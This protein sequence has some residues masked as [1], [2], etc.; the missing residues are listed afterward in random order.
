M[1]APTSFCDGFASADPSPENAFSLTGSKLGFTRRCT[2]LCSVVRGPD[3][4][5]D[6]LQQADEGRA[7]RCVLGV[8]CIS[9]GHV[10]L[11]IGIVS[12]DKAR[13]IQRGV[14]YFTREALPRRR[15]NDEERIPE[16]AP[17]KETD[18]IEARPRR[19]KWD[20]RGDSN[21]PSTQTQTGLPDWLKEKTIKEKCLQEA[22]GCALRQIVV[23]GEKANA[24]IKVD[25]DRIADEG[26]VTI[27]G[28]IEKAEV[29]IRANQPDETDLVVPPD[30][31]GWAG[32]SYGP[33]AIRE[34]CG[35]NLFI[36]V[37]PPAQGNGPHKIQIIGD[38]RELVDT[39]DK[40]IRPAEIPAAGCISQFLLAHKPSCKRKQAGPSQIGE[41]AWAEHVK[42]LLDRA[43]FEGLGPPLRP[44]VPAPGVPMPLPRT[45]PMRPITPMVPLNPV[46]HVSASP[47]VSPVLASFG[48]PRGPVVRPRAQTPP[49]AP[50]APSPCLDNI[51]PAQRLLAHARPAS[52]NLMPDVASWGTFGAGFALGQLKLAIQLCIAEEAE[53]A[54]DQQRAGRVLRTSAKVLLHKSC[55]SSRNFGT[56]RT[57][58]H[59]YFRYHD[60]N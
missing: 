55:R 16:P 12:Q 54:E 35:G 20:D 9:I 33:E 23:P 5:G 58:E 34:A 17:E 6:P 59:W 49:S 18:A 11:N 24:E 37:I 52:E 4:N 53:E 22:I 45:V 27:V 36:G 56:P 26:E 44:G 29:L 31:V 50:S 39:E 7:G 41:R 2:T 1:T 13:S 3:Q 14:R 42:T 10:V 60:A 19:S 25:H 46:S 51:P 48:A 32:S 28:E 21:S 47:M 8:C 57:G 40:K 43:A 15:R 38:Q 30:V